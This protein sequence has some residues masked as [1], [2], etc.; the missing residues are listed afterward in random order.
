MRDTIPLLAK[1]E[2]SREIFG[3]I[4]LGS[5]IA[6]YAFSVA[7]I[8]VF[9]Y[10]IY[11]R[12]R[13]WRIGQRGHIRFAPVAAFKQFVQR[14]LTQRALRKQNARKRSAATL[15]HALLFYGFIVLTIGTILV[16]IE[17]WAHDL[18]PGY[19]AR[20]PLFHKGIYFAVYEVFMDTFGLALTAGIV[21]FI[22]RRAKG[23]T[24][25]G[26][27]PADW[28]I[29]GAILFLGVSG[30]I[31]EGLRI[32]R[33]D[34]AMPG[35]SYVGYGF[36]VV[37]ELVGV[38]ESNVDTP[39]LLLWWVHA[40]VALAMIAAVPYSR[41]MHIV[42]GSLSVATQHKQ[43]GRLAPVDLEEVEA[44]GR[45][46]VGR[47]QD[48]TDRQLLELDACVSCGRCED[49]CPAFEAG[50][51]L[52]PRDVVQDVKQHL[53]QV[54]PII[55]AARKAGQ[56]EDK[57]TATEPKLHGDAISAETL[58]SCTTCNACYDV[59]PLG[60]S[61]VDLITDMRRHLIGEGELAGPPAT[62]LQKTQ[63]QGNPWGLPKNER[64]NWAEGIEVPS[65]E[66]NPTFEVLYWVGCAASYDRRV[67][68]VA[69][70]V[71]QLFQHARVNFAVLGSQE[72]CTGESARRMGDEFVFMEL[73]EGNIATLN[74]HNV[75]TI[76]THCPHCLNTLRQ[77]YPQYG[78]DYEVI[79]HSALIEQLIDEGK[80]PREPVA[81]NTG[82]A[83]NVTYHDP[84]YLAR[85]ARE[86]KAPRSLVQ[87]S[88]TANNVNDSAASFEEPERHGEETA[89]C[90]AGGGRMWFDDEP[91]KRIGQKRIDE[92]LA[93]GADTVAVGCPFCL[94]MVS[95][96]VNAR[97][98][99]VQVK[100]IAEL[101]AEALL[102]ESATTTNNT[103]P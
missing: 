12:W 49:A 28:L 97:D 63:R 22:L 74:Q 44:T 41:L 37:F 85:V 80:L 43:L 100:D 35:F 45:F 31:L 55:F 54:G 102:D 20:E 1:S 76:V 39:H 38:D 47:V 61:P 33:E 65:V 6:F 81:S 7:A 9:C 15:A 73:A 32:I 58:W 16:G 68:K 99:R 17:H 89:C 67:Q 5:K 19:S 36:A 18:L 90:G 46:G 60:V 75:K 72:N 87:L 77:D 56:D 25:V 71:V 69:R 40:I 62:A 64:F 78:G 27:R 94:T 51:P 10:G 23:K 70:A 3:N 53:N 21:W 92:L 11:R 101:L 30:Y 82:T 93:T 34:T 29:V 57:A 4:S 79:H 66:D 91:D 24:S 2:L 88:V 52:S 14:A 50:K 84:C 96:G 59:C 48:F 103:Q 13:M 83:G 8:V 26:H 98:P 95:D 86:T 42:A